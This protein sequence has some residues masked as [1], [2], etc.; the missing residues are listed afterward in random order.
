M[1]QNYNNQGNDSRRGGYS[2]GYSAGPTRGY[3]QGGY[4]PAPSQRGYAGGHNDGPTPIDNNRVGD[5]T[6]KEGMAFLFQKAE[7]RNDKSP[8]YWGRIRLNSRMYLFSG[9]TSQ[10]GSISLKFSHEGE[11]RDIN[12][13]Y[14]QACGE[15]RLNF[16]PPAKDTQP[17][18]RGEATIEHT[19]VELA[20]WEGRR[21]GVWGGKAKP[22]DYSRQRSAVRGAREMHEH[23]DPSAVGA[24]REN[25]RGS[26]SRRGYDD[27]DYQQ[28]Q[29]QNQDREISG[30]YEP[31]QA[32]PPGIDDMRW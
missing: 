6:Y 24:P 23:F 17:V 21:Q 26:R 12:G 27:G 31:E 22:D 18:I 9:W 19:N 25:Y 30:G 1:Y 15:G 29:W 13:R 16:V 10:D 4:S 28:Q 32:P 7:R 5:F 8:D 2:N 11:Q 14:P 20:F 3:Q